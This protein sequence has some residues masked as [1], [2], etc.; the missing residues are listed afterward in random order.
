MADGLLTTLT[1]LIEYGAVAWSKVSAKQHDALRPLLEGGV[2][3]REQSGSGERLVAK[4]PAVVGRFA[5]QRYPSG[6]ADA[7]AAAQRAGHL[8]TVEGV[9]HFRD[10]KRGTQHADIVLLRGRPETT[11]RCNDAEVPIGTLTATAGVASVVLDAEHNVS[12]S[13]TLAIVENQTA[14]LQA[15]ALGADFDIALYGHGRLSSRVVAWLACPT[16]ETVDVVHCPDY[17]PVGLQE[18][19]RLYAKCGNRVQLYR[20][21]NLEELLQQY[22]KSSLYR[23]G[24]PLLSSIDDAPPEVQAVAKLLTRYGCGLE[25]EI[26][27]SEASGARTGATTSTR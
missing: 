27:I 12:M 9:Q 23:D 20:P 26:L 16:M 19:A 10:A 11:V 2:L 1:A 17:D 14:F 15:E 24:H 4:R 25:Q 13:G 5:A 22:G 3:V 8:S 18:C 7:K 6:L 21:P